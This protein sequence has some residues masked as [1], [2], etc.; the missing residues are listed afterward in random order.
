MMPIRNPM[1]CARSNL[2]TGHVGLF[3]RQLDHPSD[4]DVLELVLDEILWFKEL[5]SAVPDRFFIF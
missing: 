3:G 4:E 5:E 2:L 1:D